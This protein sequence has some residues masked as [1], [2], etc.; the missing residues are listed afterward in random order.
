VSSGWDQTQADS[1]PGALGERIYSSRLLGADPA[2]VLHGGG[3]TSVK[4][5]RTD[6][7]GQE[8]EILYV[9]CSGHDLATIGADGFTGLELEAVRRLA[10]LDQVA[11]DVA[12]AELRRTAIDP[13]MPAP[14]VEALL[15]AVLPHRY[16]DHTHALSTLML[17][18]TPS[19]EQHVRAAYGS[20]ALV[21]P[22]IRPGH[23]LARLSAELIE[24]E[25]TEEMIGL[26]LMNHGLVSFG[27][28][29]REAYE[30]MLELVAL[31]DRYRT[32]RAR[33]A[34]SGAET[35]TVSDQ[36]SSLGLKV[37]RLRAELSSAAG[38][39]LTVRRD[40]RPQTL[41]FARR[42][43]VA[44]ISQSGPAT[45]D[46]VLW[47]KRVPMLG[48]DV[49]AY[50]EAYRGYYEEHREA[51]LGDEQ[52]AMLDPAPRVVLDPEL[53]LCTAGRSPRETLVASD[54]YRQTIDLILAAE[55]LEQYQA[56][57]ARDIFALEY[58][59][60]EQAKLLR[61][62]P[63]LAGQTVII[64]GAASG[65]GAACVE[66]FV[67]RGASV[68]G[69]DISPAV[70][71]LVSG[72]SYLGLACD[73]TDEDQI[74]AALERCALSFGGVDMLVLSAGVFPPSQRVSGLAIEDWRRT[75]AVNTDANLSLLRLAHP[76][77]AL[78]P[79]GGRVVIVASKNVPAP[80]P[81]AAAY[82]ASKAALTQLARVAALEW[83]ADGIR[84]NVLH[85]NAVF[86]TGI[87][88]DEVISARAAQYGL[89]P[90]QYRTNNLLGT[91][92]SSRDV[93]ELAC[94]MC[95]AAFAR[96]TGA[97]VPIDGGNERVV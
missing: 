67:A 51:V 7:F 35:A 9:K 57:P 82:S 69:L 27:E 17:T 28:S 4:L 25:L 44:T 5:P 85:P 10:A 48:R 77:L 80:G 97:Q 72:P 16:V 18:N 26:V 61:P 52:L 90:E 71:S 32:T 38:R 34:Q 21:I 42:A 20:S 56:L 47:T 60:S 41:A 53:G 12:G 79:A 11:D 84:V 76:Y 23:G 58:W 31:A 93:A 37:A 81:G 68:C 39:P 3:N 24:A 74:A 65:I 36:Q 8:Q 86:D 43:D 29:A 83:G 55:S 1:F 49:S 54:L 14:S 66:A 50:A 62:Q 89:T 96:T 59:A 33:P 78:A 13:A 22:Y 40:P 63:E 2:L 46:H 30:R 45:P 87:W 75:F 73:V 15:H 70:E 64:T 88:T 91:E 19:G 6:V 95:G 92:V 94:A